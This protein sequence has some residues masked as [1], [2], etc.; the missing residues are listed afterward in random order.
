M[1]TPT[2]DSAHD[3]VAT[4]DALKALREIQ[5]MARRTASAV[6]H[7]DPDQA[8]GDLAATINAATAALVNALGEAGLDPLKADPV[9]ELDVTGLGTRTPSVWVDGTPPAYRAAGERAS[10]AAHLAR[11]VAA[12]RMSV[13]DISNVLHPAAWKYAHLRATYATSM[14]NAATRALMAAN[15]SVADTIETHGSEWVEDAMGEEFSGRRG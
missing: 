14:F 12:T 6:V 11:F 1:T 5:W 15:V 7:R 9:A 10:D 8:A 13:Q 3:E 4:D 2:F